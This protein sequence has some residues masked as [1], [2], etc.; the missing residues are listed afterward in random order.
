MHKVSS[1]LIIMTHERF[2]E[3]KFLPWTFL[4]MNWLF[5]WHT[6]PMCKESSLK[7]VFDASMMR[8]LDFFHPWSGWAWHSP[9]VSSIGTGPARFIPMFSD[10]YRIILKLEFLNEKNMPPNIDQTTLSRK[11]GC[12][13]YDLKTVWAKICTTK[14]IKTEKRSKISEF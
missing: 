14:K 8:V 2:Y 10:K 12:F 13:W 1:W 9:N 4:L 5:Q 3:H 7:T 6:K 11:T